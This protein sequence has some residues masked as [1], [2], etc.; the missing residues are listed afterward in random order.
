MYFGKKERAILTHSTFIELA[1]VSVIRGPRIH[2][3]SDLRVLCV[4]AVNLQQ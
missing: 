1:L 2:S 4:S 3:L